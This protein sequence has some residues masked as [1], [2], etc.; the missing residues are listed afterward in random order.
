[1]VMQFGYSQKNKLDFSSPVHV[2]S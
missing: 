1:M 2:T